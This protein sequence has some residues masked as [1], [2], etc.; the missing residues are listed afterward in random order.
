VIGLVHVSNNAM[1][2][3]A[4]N[5]GIAVTNFKVGLAGCLF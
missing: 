2:N 3:A 1:F 4:C 5:A